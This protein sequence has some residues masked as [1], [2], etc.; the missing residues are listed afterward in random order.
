MRFSHIH[1]ASRG[2][3]WSRFYKLVESSFRSGQYEGGSLEDQT[4]FRCHDDFVDSAGHTM[5]AVL[6][7][8]AYKKLT[9]L[10]DL[11]LKMVSLDSSSDAVLSDLDISGATYETA[12]A[13][14]RK[15]LTSISW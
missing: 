4:E 5:R 2:L 14:A 9:G 7:L 10:Y 13:A 11:R 12:I 8:R 1:L 3:G 15:Y 6:C